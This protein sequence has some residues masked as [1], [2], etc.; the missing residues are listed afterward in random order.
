L[1]LFRDSSQSILDSRF[2]KLFL[3]VTDFTFS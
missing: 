3:V 1:L 2:E